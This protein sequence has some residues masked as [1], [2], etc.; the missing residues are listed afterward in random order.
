MLRQDVIAF[1]EERFPQALAE[2]WDRTGLQ[3][4]PLDAPCRR[5]LVALD[6]DLGLVPTLQGVDLLITHHPLL[7]RPLDRLLPGTPL[8]D[9][10]RALL[11]GGAACYAVHTPYDVARGGLG[12]VLADL[13]GLHGPR[14]LVPRGR[15]IKL[16]VF[17]PESH[18]DAVAAAV[19]AAGAG[20]IGR[21]GHCSFRAPGTGTF[22]PGEGTRPYIGA[23]G[24]EERV[25]EV[26]LETVVPAE[27]LTQAL[28][29][30]RAAHPYEEVAYDVYPL[31]NAAA[32]HGLG[33][34]GDLLQETPARE[35]V[36]RLACALEASG[37]RSTYGDLDRPVRRVAI[38]GGDGGDL[39]Q[40]AF[41]AG[42]ELYL[43]GEIGYHQGLEA[44]ESGLAVAALGHRE[45]ERPFVGHVA[46]LLREQFP[47]LEVIAA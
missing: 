27:R 23:I 21:Y 42:A 45:T 6:L 29:A 5:A 44:A 31:E 37:P 35:V 47:S 4:G 22:L 46:G 16:V 7:F 30:L 2:P 24:R 13:L 34:V 14:P 39:W 20:Q 19:F 41:T 11:A 10:V 25:D 43:T 17:V 15:L 9:K 18:A 3:V 32:W 8:G 36:A 26:R 40:D 12:E 1:L 38:C 28:S 33:R